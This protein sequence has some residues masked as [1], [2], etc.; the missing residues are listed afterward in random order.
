M[1]ENNLFKA[2]SEKEKLLIRNSVKMLEKWN[3]QL[4]KESLEE[5]GE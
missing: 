1:E 2:N 5:Q 4:E 3:K